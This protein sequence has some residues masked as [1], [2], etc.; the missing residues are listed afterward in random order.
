MAIFNIFYLPS[1]HFMQ[2]QF[3]QFDLRSLFL[4]LR[5]FP[6]GYFYLQPNCLRYRKWAGATLLLVLFALFRCILGLK[7]K[8]PHPQARSALHFPFEDGSLGIEDFDRRIFLRCQQVSLHSLRNWN[9]WTMGKWNSHAV[10]RQ[11]P[12]RFFHGF[13]F[14]P[15]TSRTL[16][17]NLRWQP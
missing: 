11:D 6:K 17:Y 15:N 12:K 7:A 3:L 16:S 5:F 14:G 1:H 4:L 8:G 9:L 13:S 10:H 2:K